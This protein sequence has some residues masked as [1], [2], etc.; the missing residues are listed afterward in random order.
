MITK[1]RKIL[2]LLEQ[3]YSFLLEDAKYWL[4]GEILCVDCHEANGNHT[5]DCERIKILKDVG[6]TI[7]ALELEEEENE[8]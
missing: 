4:D 5:E 6:A 1:E 7:I 8:D 2:R 3:V